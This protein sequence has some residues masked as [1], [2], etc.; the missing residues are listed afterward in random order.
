M[1]ALNFFW[2]T[3]S[4]DLHNKKIHGTAM[5]NFN[6]FADETNNALLQNISEKEIMDRN[7]GIE[8]IY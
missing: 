7:D 6:L 3:D 4:V 2:N 8:T 5:N 1:G